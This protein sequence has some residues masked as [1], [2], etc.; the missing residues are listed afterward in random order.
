MEGGLD[1]FGRGGADAFNIYTSFDEFGGVTDVQEE[2][3]L[4][5]RSRGD[6]GLSSRRT[7]SGPTGSISWAACATTCSG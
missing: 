4:R 1:Y 3:P 6:L 2:H 7:S 5:H